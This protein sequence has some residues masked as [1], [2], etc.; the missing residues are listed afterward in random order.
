MQNIPGSLYF[1]LIA[2]TPLGYGDFRHL[3]GWGII[4]TG[5]EAFIGLS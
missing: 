2:F 1:S 4:L 5:L 3:E